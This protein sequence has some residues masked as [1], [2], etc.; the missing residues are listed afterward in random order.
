MNDKT[1]TASRFFLKS[2]IIT[3]EKSITRKG[4]S[5]TADKIVAEQPFGFW[6]S[7]FD[8]HHY[9]LI[10][11]VVIHSFKYKPPGINRNILNQKLNRIREFRN[12]IYHNEPICFRDNLTDFTY[13]QDIKNEILE[14]L[15]WIDPDLANYDDYFDAID[16]KINIAKNM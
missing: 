1:L 3:A 13:A 16:I 7:L 15:C 6:T 12:R 9:R 5:I 4:R 10:G 14:L 2:S 8:T 11:G